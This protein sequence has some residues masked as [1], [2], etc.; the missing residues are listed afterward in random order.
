MLFFLQNR[1]VVEQTGKQLKKEKNLY[2]NRMFFGDWADLIN[3][4]P[5]KQ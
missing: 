3:V 4:I 5:S 2:N 1:E